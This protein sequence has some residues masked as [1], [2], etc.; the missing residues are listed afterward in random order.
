V[1]GIYSSNQ[2]I[3]E[4]IRYFEMAIQIEPEWADPYLKLAY[5]SLN[6]GDMA[7]AA[8]NLEKCI[9]LEPDTE[10]TVQAKNILATIKK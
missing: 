3:A 4:V 6:K 2:Q 1:A 7:K 8:E 5:A 10:R 9:K